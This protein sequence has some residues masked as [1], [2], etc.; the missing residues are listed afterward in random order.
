MTSLLA[1]ADDGED[2]S[3][4]KRSSWAEVFSVKRRALRFSTSHAK[5]ANSPGTSCFGMPK[6]RRRCFTPNLVT[7]DGNAPWNSSSSSEI[8][9]ACTW[10]VEVGDLE[11]DWYVGVMVAKWL[12]NR[13]L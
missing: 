13:S 11:G 4:D 6:R 10:D 3:L 2:R 12:R 7:Q 9:G 5:A 8:C 1:I